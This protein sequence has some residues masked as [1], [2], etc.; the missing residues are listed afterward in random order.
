MLVRCARI[1]IELLRLQLCSSHP[2]ISMRTPQIVACICIYVYGHTCTC[3]KPT[4]MP[5]NSTDHLS[6]LQ[7]RGGSADAAVQ[8]KDTDESGSSSSGNVSSSHPSS[9]PS[10]DPSSG[11]GSGEG[12]GGN[13]GGSDGGGGGGGV[14]GGNGSGSLSSPDQ[15][16]TQTLGEN[17]SKSEGG[18]D[19]HKKSSQDSEAQESQGVVSRNTSS[20][21]LSLSRLLP[22][23]PSPGR[24]ADRSMSVTSSY[25]ISSLEGCVDTSTPVEGEEVKGEKREE[26]GGK[27]EVVEGGR[28][29]G[30]PTSM[31]SLSV[32]YGGGCEEGG[33]ERGR[34]DKPPTTVATEDRVDSA[35]CEGM[36]R[37]NEGAGVKRDVLEDVDSALRDSDVNFDRVKEGMCEEC[38]V[39]GTEDGLSSS[40]SSSWKLVYNSS[41][42]NTCS[43]AKRPNTC[44][45]VSAGQPS[46]THIQQTPVLEDSQLPDS[47]VP[48]VID[49]PDSQDS[50]AALMSCD[51]EKGG[52]ARD[53][54]GNEA[55]S[56]NIEFSL[57]LS[58]SQTETTPTQEEARYKA[59]PTTVR[60][61]LEPVAILQ[62]QKE[63]ELSER[64]TS[65]RIPP[66]LA[67]S[68]DLQQTSSGVECH[69]AGR[70][71]EGV[72]SM[73]DQS[74]GF[75]VHRD[76]GGG[77]C[78][79]KPM[80]LG[81]EGVVDGCR[82]EVVGVSHEG[83]VDMG[84]E[85]AVRER[86]VP[87]YDS[88]PVEEAPAA[89]EASSLPTPQQDSQQ[90]QQ[91]QQQQAPVV[92]C[93]QNPSNETSQMSSSSAGKYTY[94]Y[95]YIV[96]CVR[97][98][99]ITPVCLCVCVCVYE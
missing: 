26:E 83:T 92:V 93:S 94:I 69:G 53:I 71:G 49:V 46:H 70:G 79:E 66:S 99:V 97:V 18:R 86:P 44:T 64:A 6:C 16:E 58:Q 90:Q 42:S 98:H 52:G 82:E 63:V 88:L 38:A 30:G 50:Q 67:C 3:I 77:A 11:T 95:M 48:L 4:F 59:T 32:G 75:G 14:S 61:L 72:V 55:R 81:R 28:I 78:C 33:G 43:E 24:E 17:E 12:R 76:E 29:L 84:H 47:E 65:V 40:H 73:A 62:E 37:E 2:H 22:A 27:I 36:Q 7:R 45:A 9:T 25:P 85:D 51:G 10:S 20:E 15:S 34:E 1:L 8:R 74:V 39:N 60:G 13:G 41:N 91:Q 19:R 87:V 68:E 5:V 96:M 21:S 31:V 89:F 54:A 57:H 56:Q 35:V 23:N 80:D